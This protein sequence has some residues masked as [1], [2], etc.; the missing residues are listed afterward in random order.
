MVKLGY[1]PN[2]VQII[3][4]TLDNSRVAASSTPQM[5]AKPQFEPEILNIDDWSDFEEE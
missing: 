1:D 2:L 3:P 5:R 4:P